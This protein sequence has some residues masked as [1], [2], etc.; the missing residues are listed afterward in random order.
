MRLEICNRTP[1]VF[2]RS[3]FNLDSVKEHSTAIMDE[4]ED[5]S[6]NAMFPFEGLVYFGDEFL[7]PYGRMFP[8]E[9]LHYFG[10]E[11]PRS[12]G[13]EKEYRHD[14]GMGLLRWTGR[15]SQVN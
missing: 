2:D 13:R 8:F 11:F 9:G 12:D 6:G 4:V 5:I 14:I 10:D 15:P 3:L 1:Q 7:R